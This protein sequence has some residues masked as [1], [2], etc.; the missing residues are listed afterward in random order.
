MVQMHRR[1]RQGPQRTLVSRCW[2]VQ[3]HQKKPSGKLS[4]GDDTRD[5]L[6]YILWRLDIFLLN[7]VVARL[8]Q[9]RDIC[10]I[11]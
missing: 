7:V 1:Q 5:G 9:T 10:R 11:M 2:A 8:T 6:G 4:E 3:M